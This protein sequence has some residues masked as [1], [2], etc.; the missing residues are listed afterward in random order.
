M[1]ER[2][3][4]MQ[5]RL[6][7]AADRVGSPVRITVGIAGAIDR[8]ASSPG[9]VAVITTDRA[10]RDPS[11]ARLLAALPDDAIWPHA[12]AHPGPELIERATTELID[13]RP[14]TVLGLGGGSVLDLTKIAASSL[15]SREEVNLIQVPTTAGTGADVTCWGTFWLADGTKRSF[16]SAATGWADD[17]LVIPELTMSAI[18]A[19][20]SAHR[21]ALVEAAT[22]AGLALS[23]TRSAAAHALSYSFTGMYGLEHG[24]AVGLMWRGLL[25]EIAR[26]SP[27][28]VAQILEG[29]RAA[30][31]EAALTQIDRWF[32]AADLSPTLHCF[33]LP[34]NAG[35]DA[36]DQ[37][38]NSNRLANQPGVWG[39]PE[40]LAAL[41]RIT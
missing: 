10:R 26:Q 14:G 33:G 3:R 21:E 36:V 30:S 35:L 15:R 2:N 8:I 13:R 38:L 11:A 29:L 28:A 34:A 9:P 32:A 5:D 23:V 20:T 4:A 12:Q 18:T 39:R 31:V 24:L 17:A 19:P 40:L 27:D 16:E 22:L 41:D 25:P 7:R 6:R 37:A 1:S